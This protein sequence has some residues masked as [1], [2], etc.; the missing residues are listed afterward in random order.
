MKRLMI[1]LLAVSLL[2]TGCSSVQQP[3]PPIMG[4][5]SNAGEKTVVYRG[6]QNF[7]LSF[8]VDG[9]QK[10]ENGTYWYYELADAYKKDWTEPFYTY[11]LKELELNGSKDY[12]KLDKSKC[13]ATNGNWPLFLNPV[14]TEFTESNQKSVDASLIGFMQQQ[15]VANQMEGLPVVITDVW[16]CDMDGNGKEETLFKACNCSKEESGSSYCFVGYSAGGSCQGLYSAFRTEGG[17]DLKTLEPMV[18]DLNGDGV[19]SVML[20]K[21][22]DYQ[23]FT[24]YDLNSGNF[25]KSYEVIF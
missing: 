21:K 7:T 9:T 23:S 16:G 8:S 11:D 25:T 2:F 4:E 24:V 19:W 10:I 22:G 18:C 15:L 5:F 12:T 14:H 1:L 13:F 3:E 6:D 20:Y 17:C